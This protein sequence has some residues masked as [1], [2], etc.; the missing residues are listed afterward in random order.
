MGYSFVIIIVYVTNLLITL[1]AFVWSIIVASMGA[2]WLHAGWSGFGFEPWSVAALRC[3]L[4]QVTLISQCLSPPRYINGYLGANLMLGVTVW[5]CK[6][7]ICS[8]KCDMHWKTHDWKTNL[9][10]TN[11]HQS[12]FPCQ[13]HW[14]GNF[15]AHSIAGGMKIKR[16]SCCIGASPLSQFDF[17]SLPMIELC[18]IFSLDSP[19]KQQVLFVR[20]PFNLS[21][22]RVISV[23]VIF[24]GSRSNSSKFSVSLSAWRIAEVFSHSFQ[25]K[26]VCFE[27]LI[28]SL[29]S[30]FANAW[31]NSIN[32]HN[33]DWQAWHGN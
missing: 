23:S 18:D 30:V 2:W 26:I 12:C 29:D 31:Q 19:A 13:N 24:Y 25:I 4:G 7:A 5:K 3:V 22:F 27:L 32:W 6:E 17:F 33:Y 11:K 16:Y 15:C 10:K 28:E 9:F 21:S 20:Q 8:P 14:R 1:W